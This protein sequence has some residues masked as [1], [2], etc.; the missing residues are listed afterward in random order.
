[1]KTKTILGIDE[2]G[3]GPWAGPLVVG[4][5]ILGS[6]FPSSGLEHLTDSKKLSAA[7]REELSAIIL[8]QA[9]ATGLGWVSAAEV[10]HYG[11]GLALKLAARRAAKQVL[12]TKVPFDEIIIDGTINLLAETPLVDRVTLLKKADLL[13]KEVS[14]AS[15]I[16]KVARDR[17]MYTLAEKYPSYGFEKHVGYGTAAHQSALRELGPCP[18]HRRSFRPIRELIESSAET[19]TSETTTATGQAAETAVLDYLLAHSHQL[20]AHNYKTKLYEI[21]LITTLNSQIFFTEVKYRKSSRHGTPLASITAKKQRQIAFAAD[22]F[23]ATHP[24]FG[25]FQPRLAVASVVPPD[26]QVE[27]WFPLDAA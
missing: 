19:T 6:N 4:A 21:D 8:D 9:A 18:E 27:T 16:A 15:I 12:A 1:M 2:V 5:T 26:F 11:L 17:Y 25:S 13:I 3:R 24:E 20:I 10:D 14:A 22:A 23:L 7:R